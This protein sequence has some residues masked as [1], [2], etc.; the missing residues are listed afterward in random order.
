MSNKSNDAK[1]YAGDLQSKLTKHEENDKDF[2]ESLKAK[3]LDDLEKRD[4]TKMYD[5]DE[6]K[7]SLVILENSLTGVEND[8]KTLSDESKSTLAEM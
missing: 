8:V 6:I 3:D 2:D 4:Q 1:K 7:K 5:P